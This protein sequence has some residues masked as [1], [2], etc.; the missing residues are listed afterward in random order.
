MERKT[1]PPLKRT[2]A[3]RSRVVWSRHQ[4]GVQPL[5]HSW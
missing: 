5:M 1:F 4:A 2:L 3:G